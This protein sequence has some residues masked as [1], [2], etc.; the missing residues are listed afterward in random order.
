MTTT[1]AIQEFIWTHRRDDPQRMALSARKYPDLPM[2]YI[3]GQID[4][5]QKIE[6][7]VPSWYREGLQFPAALSME[8]ASSEATARFKAGLFSGQKMAD[9]SGGLGVDSFFFAQV[10]ASA[11]YVESNVELADVVRHNFEAL[12]VRNTTFVASDAEHFLRDTD[13]TFDLLYLDPSRRHQQKGKV[14]QLQD[15][16][17]NILALKNLAL[18][19]SPRILVKTAPWL[20]IHL[21]ARQLEQVRHIWVVASG[22]ECR[23]VLYAL[24]REPVPL[25]QIP[26]QAVQINKDGSLQSFRFSYAEENAAEVEYRLPQQ[27]LYEPN[28]AILK[29]G[30]FRSFARQ[31]GLAKLQQHTHLYTSTDYVVGLPARAF[32][33]EAVCKYDRKAVQACVPGNKANISTRNFPDNAEAVR[34]KL[35]LADG[36]DVYL[37]AVTDMDGKK[38]LVVG[39]KI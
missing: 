7:K 5:L 22:D 29:S 3:A 25:E 39:K 35:G 2:A 13:E 31:Y 14:F 6:K 27:F 9:L 17:P 36:G 10:F 4:F 8:Q 24:E 20:D 21:A 38:V 28:P 37:F 19:K 32:A 30:A 11:T 33:I 16:S 18:E 26:I 12:G 34:K 1:A 23:E 15:C